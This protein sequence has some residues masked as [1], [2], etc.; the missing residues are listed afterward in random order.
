MNR[1]SER[2]LYLEFVKSA[3]FDQNGAEFGPAFVPQDVYKCGEI[4][5]TVV[6]Y[7]FI[8]SALSRCYVKVNY[9]LI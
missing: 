5:R 1:V 4:E 3:Q 9:S 7:I 2:F 8:I 6:A